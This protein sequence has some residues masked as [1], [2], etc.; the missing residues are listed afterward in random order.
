MTIIGHASNGYRLWDKENE[1]VL[2][3]RDVTFYYSK[4][5]K[6]SVKKEVV[7]VINI[8]NSQWEF[9]KCSQSSNKS[10]FERK[11]KG[12]YVKDSVQTGYVIT[13]LISLHL[14]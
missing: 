14:I 13:T 6:Q 2:V 5:I 3:A 8:E 12:L 9:E 1:K 7:S 10:V 4:S 11:N